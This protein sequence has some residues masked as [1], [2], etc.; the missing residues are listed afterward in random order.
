VLP[1]EAADV[2]DTWPT[3]KQICRLTRSRQRKIAGTWSETVEVVYLVT[4]LEPERASPAE[5]LSLNRDHWGIE[6]MHRHKDFTL[7]EDGYTNRCDHA[8]RNIST[9]LAFALRI[10]KTVSTS[11]TRAIEHFQDNRNRAIRLFEQIH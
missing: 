5:L 7:G 8:P 9:M 1:A 4:S 11:P 10:L 3:I 6:V 2:A